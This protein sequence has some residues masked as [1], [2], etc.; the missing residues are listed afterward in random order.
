MGIRVQIKRKRREF[1]KML[2]KRKK[3]QYKKDLITLKKLDKQKKRE[4]VKLKIR[5]KKSQ[6]KKIKQ[7]E[8]GSGGDF[9]GVLAKVG[10]GISKADFGGMLED[11]PSTSPPSPFDETPT[12]SK[13]KRRKKEQEDL[14]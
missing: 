7:K 9:M 10:E 12:K 5:K 11:S 8:K 14:W 6:I 3:E 13:K 1:E 4:G 2:E